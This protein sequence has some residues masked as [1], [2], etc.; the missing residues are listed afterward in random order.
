M[1]GGGAYGR[2]VIEGKPFLRGLLQV[3]G[4]SG[5]DDAERA[6]TRSGSGA[7]ALALDRYAS[8]LRRAPVRVGLAVAAAD[9]IVFGRAR[10]RAGLAL[11]WL[12]RRA[13]FRGRRELA[14]ES[15]GAGAG[16]YDAAART[17]R[18]CSGL[19]CILTEAAVPY[20]NAMR[21]RHAVVAVVASVTAA[22]GR[23]LLCADSRLFSTLAGAR[24]FTAVLL[25]GVSAEETSCAR[26]C[27][28]SRPTAT[29]W[30]GR[31]AWR[32]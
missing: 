5:W 19:S 30:A 32:P 13:A 17:D 27:C 26:L 23:P 8:G 6:V 10:L 25:F 2:P 7:G 9:R 22:N 18:P 20:R 16:A 12:V 21:V 29:D 3:A 31:H 1:S 4:E 14:E 28:A 11:P 24:D 15:R